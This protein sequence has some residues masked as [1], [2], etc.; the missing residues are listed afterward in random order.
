MSVRGKGKVEVKVSKN[1]KIKVK[2]GNLRNTLWK[3]YYLN[4]R[5]VA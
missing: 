2:K 3:L 5:G 1:K 4:K